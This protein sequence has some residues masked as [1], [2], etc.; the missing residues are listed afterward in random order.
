MIIRFYIFS[1]FHLSCLKN[2]SE[3]NEGARTCGGGMLDLPLR[4]PGFLPLPS[5]ILIFG[6]TFEQTTHLSAK[7]PLNLRP[8]YHQTMARG[9]STI[10]VKCSCFRAKAAHIS[11]HLPAAKN[12]CGGSTLPPMSLSPRG[13]H[14]EPQRRISVVDRLYRA[15]T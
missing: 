5:Q 9:C 11:R 14:S 6:S 2:T 1:C 10:R 3:R 15:I 8:K 4:K 12:L 13:C 7:N